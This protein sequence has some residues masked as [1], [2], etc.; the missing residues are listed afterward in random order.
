[1][2]KVRR[3][4][5]IEFRTAK[6][7]IG[8]KAGDMDRGRP[9]SLEQGQRTGIHD[10][11]RAVFELN[12][13]GVGVVGETTSDDKLDFVPE[14]DQ[15]ITGQPVDEQLSCART[16]VRHG[17]VVVSDFAGPLGVGRGEKSFGNFTIAVGGEM[18]IV[19]ENVRVVVRGKQDVV[20]T[21]EP[22]VAVSI[23]EDDRID[24]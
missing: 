13:F 22:I 6:L 5:A 7:G 8:V 24:E 17:A 19:P 18:N 16:V 12:L 4:A 23:R 20:P 14:R 2:A 21:I 15:V 1:M 10:D 11:F 9:R 3:P